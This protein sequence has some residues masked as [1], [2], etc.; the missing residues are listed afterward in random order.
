MRRKRVFKY[1]IA[2]WINFFPRLDIKQENVA[3][4]KIF[5]IPVNNLSLIPKRQIICSR[6]SFRT[7][8]IRL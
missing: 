8:E 6:S 5:I 3:V 2:Y 4:N 1:E 7:F